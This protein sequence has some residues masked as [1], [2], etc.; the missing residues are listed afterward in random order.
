MPL[1]RSGDKKWPK[2]K[3]LN[4]SE[5]KRVYLL[6]Y[7]Q[8]R[9]SSFRNVFCPIIKRD[10]SLKPTHL[11]NKCSVLN[12][13]SRI[14]QKL[15]LWTDDNGSRSS[16]SPNRCKYVGAAMGMAN[17]LRICG[18]WIFWTPITRKCGSTLG[19]CFLAQ[20]L[21]GSGSF[22]LPLST[23][24]VGF[25]GHLSPRAMGTCFL[26]GLLLGRRSKQ[27]I[28]CQMIML[29]RSTLIGIAHH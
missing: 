1:Q 23:T 9:I 21:G 4:T 25:L 11:Q 8:T 19:T 27:C 3:A 20:L 26:R 16:H 2:K 18:H 12:M 28:T 17:L 5:L 14:S 15:G 6:T 10:E 22:L 7:N 24:N 29:R 13:W